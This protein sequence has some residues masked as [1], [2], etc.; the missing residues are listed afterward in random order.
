VSAAVTVGQDVLP[1][2]GAVLASRAWLRRGRP[3]PHVVAW[4]VFKPDFYAGMARQVRALLD[5]QLS[6][7]P[8]GERFSR[9]IAGYDAYGVGLRPGQPGPLGLFLSP[10]WRDLMCG[11]FG[12]GATPYV[13][14]GAHHHTVGSAHGFI[15]NDLN[16]VWFPAAGDREIQVPNNQV[17][18]YKTGFGSLAEPE[19]VQVVRG[20]A[21]IFYLLNDGW[22][23]GDGGETGLYESPYASITDPAVRCPPENNSL[24][25]FECSPSSFHSFLSNRRLPR[26][27]IIMWVHRALDEA[28]AKFGAERLEQW[29]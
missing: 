24:I 7:T 19:K 8:D 3:F 6:E 18:A 9:N 4:D 29:R 21:V 13:F 5:R 23:S 2:L 10:G 20:A 12:V 11:L 1:S 27:S 26:T 15:H 25:A 22:A 28:V 14:A 17:C 16:P